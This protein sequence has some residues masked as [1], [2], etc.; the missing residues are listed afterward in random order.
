MPSEIGLQVMGPKGAK[1]QMS[2]KPISE[3]V[4]KGTAV[5]WEVKQVA[6]A[7]GTGRAWK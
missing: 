1:T 4:H 5:Q 7:S 2:Q 3:I 6:P